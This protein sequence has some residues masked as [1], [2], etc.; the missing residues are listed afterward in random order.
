MMLQVLMLN[1]TCKDNYEKL[2]FARDA[3]TIGRHPSIK[4]GLGFQKRTKNLT[5]QRTSTLNK[6]KG[7][8]LMT[9]SSSQD[10]TNHAYLYAHVKNDSNVAHHDRSYN[11]A[12]LPNRH[13]A[14]F[15]SHAMFASSSSF[16]HGRNRPR[17]HHIA[18]HAPMSHPDFRGTKTR[19]RTNHQVCLDQV[20]HI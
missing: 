4:D 1:L 8:G 13:D 2:K 6:E 17:H 12:A 3:Y 11:H 18:S 5:T 19:A 16:A 10:Q 15:N 9:S 7:K 14:T 20:S